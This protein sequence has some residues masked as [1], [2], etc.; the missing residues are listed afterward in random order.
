MDEGVSVVVEVSAEA[1]GVGE[2]DLAVGEVV[3][4][5]PTSGQETG[6][7]RTQ[8]KFNLQM[9]FSAA[10]FTLGFFCL[11]HFVLVLAFDSGQKKRIDQDNKKRRVAERRERE[12]KAEKGKS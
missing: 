8:G 12:G 5:T 2:V 3:A 6:L 4:E 7:A 9:S 11:S 10:S 1:G